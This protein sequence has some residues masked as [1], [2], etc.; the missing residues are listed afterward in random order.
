[1]RLPRAST[2][3]QLG[4]LS[5]CTAQSACM[6]LNVANGLQP[7]HMSWCSTLRVER[8]ELC[9]TS[10]KQLQFVHICLQRWQRSIYI[11]SPCCKRLQAGHI[12]ARSHRMVIDHRPHLLCA[13]YFVCKSSRNTADLRHCVHGVYKDTAKLCPDACIATR[14]VK[15]ICIASLFCLETHAHLQSLLQAVSFVE[16]MSQLPS[17]IFSQ[18]CKFSRSV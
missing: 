2:Q 15:N 17:R 10:T 11:A 13:K 18:V 12:G 1:M 3:V 6:F 8:L 4:I 5:V 14:A 9:Q 7:Q 16:L